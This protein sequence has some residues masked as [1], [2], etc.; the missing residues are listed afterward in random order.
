MITCWDINILSILDSIKY[1]TT[2]DSTS[3]YFLNVATRKMWTV[4]MAHI[5]YLSGSTGLLFPSDKVSL[6][7]F[8]IK[9]GLNSEHQLSCVAPST[10]W[11]IC[12]K[13]GVYGP[14]K[15]ERIHPNSAP[16]HPHFWECSKLQV[17][18]DILL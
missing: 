1:I 8:H 17:S 6:S 16:P 4:C 5:M 3:F 7:G 12:C 10:V 13:I 18:S 15:L 11:H 14:W 2:V 9:V